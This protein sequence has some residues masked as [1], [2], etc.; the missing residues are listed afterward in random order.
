MI[1]NP[2]YSTSPPA[3]AR[4]GLV[5]GT[6][7]KHTELKKKVGPGV[8]TL[9]CSWSEALNLKWKSPCVLLLMHPTSVAKS[10][11]ETH[12]SGALEVFFC[13]ENPLLQP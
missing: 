10:K 5:G 11:G 7:L 4:E 3:A 13:E 8:M 6:H 12:A 1:F 9:R 2:Q